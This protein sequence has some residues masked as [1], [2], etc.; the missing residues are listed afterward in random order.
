MALLIPSLFSLLY[1]TSTSSGYGGVLGIAECVFMCV[2]SVG[3]HHWGQPRISKL[4]KGVKCS[5]CDV[6]ITRVPNTALCVMI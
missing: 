5:L 3:G 2:F 6:S 4:E 1:V